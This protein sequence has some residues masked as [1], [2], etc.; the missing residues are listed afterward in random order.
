MLA[1]LQAYT[2]KQS[3][4]RNVRPE[5]MYGLLPEPS[6]KRLV[7]PYKIRSQCNAKSSTQKMLPRKR[8]VSSGSSNESDSS[9][10]DSQDTAHSTM[11]ESDTVSIKS[12]PSKK[13]VSGE[14]VSGEENKIFTLEEI[15]ALGNKGEFPKRTFTFGNKT[16]TFF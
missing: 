10:E 8:T 9:S 3:N 1:T 5:S 6:Q 14:D 11:N 7:D 4:K 12:K 15:L 2:E 13:V 16:K